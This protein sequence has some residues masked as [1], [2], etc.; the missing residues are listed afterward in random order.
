MP[1]RLLSDWFEN[2]AK[3]APQSAQALG[4]YVANDLLRELSES[5]Q[6]VE[7][8][9]MTPD[10]LLSLVQAVD[11]GTITKQ[12]AKEV[13]IEMFNSGETA[14]QVVERKG[15]KPD[16]DENQVK[17]WCQEAIDEN[18]RS[19]EDYR[20]GN[21]KALNALLGPVMKKSRGK[22]NPQLVNK[23]IRSLLS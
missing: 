3:Q 18:P 17:T 4:N 21:E 7:D 16:F 9:R 14:D 5:N 2:A 13:F 11:K 15:L 12:I 1:D 23:L 22:A 6:T 8:C 19:V 10:T 20:A